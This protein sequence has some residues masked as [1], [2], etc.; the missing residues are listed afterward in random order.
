MNIALIH[1]GMR[2][3]GISQQILNLGGYLVAQGHEV[4][5]VSYE[6]GEWWARLADVGLKGVCLPVGRWESAFQHARRLA[7]F[8]AKG[9][10]DVVMVF[11]PTRNLSGQHCLPF[12]PS[13][14]IRLVAL[15]STGP[16]VFDRAAINCGVW[17][18]AI[19]VSP[20]IE[21][22]ATQRFSCKEVR[23][24][25]NGVT[26]PSDLHLMQRVD[27]LKPLRLLFVGRLANRAKNIVLL[28]EILR[29]CAQAGLPVTLTIIGDGQ[30]RSL[31]EQAINASR[32]L[33]R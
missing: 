13:R 24:I 8:L 12:L 3:G 6:E 17:D 25:P 31:L 9:K 26:L 5:V 18:M 32:R 11:L 30:D 4:T 22:I 10:F 16:T 27:W 15:H 21:K 33:W 14:M 23:C 2:I 28:P 29:I 7:W 20:A 1:Y 19:A